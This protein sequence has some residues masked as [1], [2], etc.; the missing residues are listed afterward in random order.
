MFIKESFKLQDRPGDY[1]KFTDRVSDFALQLNFKKS[2][3]TNFGYRIKEKHS[4]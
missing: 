4:Q 2:P 3:L 1:I